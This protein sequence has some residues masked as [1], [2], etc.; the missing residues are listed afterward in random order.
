MG[1]EDGGCREEEEVTA[2]LTWEAA[3]PIPVVVQVTSPA[4]DEQ[5]RGN[6]GLEKSS[7]EPGALFA[8][9]ASPGEFPP[10]PLTNTG[11]H[12]GS[13]RDAEPPG[14][15][16]GRLPATPG[17]PRSSTGHRDLDRTGWGRRS[18]SRR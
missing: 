13:G 3:C 7:G 8:G 4:L 1:M 10:G 9:F 6:P 12:G 17:L 15:S 5:Q 18:R 14:S 11:T 16:A 2:F